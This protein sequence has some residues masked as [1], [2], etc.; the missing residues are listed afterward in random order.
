MVR[1]IIPLLLM[2]LVYAQDDVTSTHIKLYK[3]VSSA[4]VGIKG[5]G[6]IGSGVVVSAEGVIL[7]STTAAGTKGEADVYLKGHKKVK[8]RIVYSD[9]KLELAIVR[10]SKDQV[11][12]VIQMG[13]SDVVKVG[14][15]AY[16]LGDSRDSIFTDD[17][18]AFSVGVISAIYKLDEPKGGTYKGPVFETS[19]AVNPNQDGG[20]LLDSKGNLVGMLSLSYHEA[21]YEGVAIPVNLF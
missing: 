13:D 21:R 11:Q 6:Q 20:A 2:S 4:I 5:Q 1:A 17:Q 8:G 9:A 18:V 15:V 7:S 12:A 3:K 10:I 19:A 16:T 14:Q